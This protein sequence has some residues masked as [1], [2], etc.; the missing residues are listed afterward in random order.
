MSTEYLKL[1]GKCRE[2]AEQAVA[3]DPS[4]TLVRGHYHC[5]T[6]GKQ[7]HWWAARTN[8]T[9][10]D[11]TAD[12]F[13][14]RGIGHY[15]PYDGIV[16]CSQCGKEIPEESA[17]FDGNGHYAFCSDLCHGRFVGVFP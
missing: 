5:P 4:L 1:R 13:P 7:A 6:W 3:A 14:S 17:S 12:Q 2:L 16:E 9:I 15:E 11:P 8:G 10:Y